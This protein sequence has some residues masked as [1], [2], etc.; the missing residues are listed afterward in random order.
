MRIAFLDLNH[1]TCGIHTN[2]TPLGSGLIATYLR[3]NID[4]PFDI[5]IFKN[6]DRLLE[7]K[8]WVPDVA[9]LAQY[10][11]NSELNLYGA[12]HIKAMNP[13]CLVISGGPNQDLDAEKRQS[14]LKMIR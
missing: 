5:R 8:D 9:G 10:V 4:H 3:K 11:W 6:I 7:T 1:A 14:F 2:T 13:K 12:R